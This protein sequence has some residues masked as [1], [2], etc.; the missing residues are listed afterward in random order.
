MIL[1]RNCLLV[2]VTSDAPVRYAAMLMLP[3][4]VIHAYATESESKLSCCISTI[5]NWREEQ[6]LTMKLLFI[7]RLHQ[8]DDFLNFPRH[9]LGAVLPVPALYPHLHVVM[10][11]QESQGF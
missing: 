8:C 1:Q 11:N 2:L 9:F 3:S 10:E 4:G 7:F 5:L 6:G